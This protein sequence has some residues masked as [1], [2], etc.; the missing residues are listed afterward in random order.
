M[1]ISIP[2]ATTGVADNFPSGS[3]GFGPVSISWSVKGGDE[4]DVSVSVLG[5]NVDQLSGTL[6]P[7]A[8]SV[9]D[10]LNIL[11]VIT[12]ALTLTAKYSQG[13][14]IDGLWVSGQVTAGP[15]KSGTLNHRILPW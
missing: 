3:W 11:G 9:S 4:I 6:S 10:N 13:P 5:I 12:G 14:A 7:T 1:A 8:T 15:W 2:A